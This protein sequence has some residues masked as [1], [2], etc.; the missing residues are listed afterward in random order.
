METIKEIKS[1]PVW[2]FALIVALVL[3]ITMFIFSIV[4]SILGSS[5]FSMM[6]FF[7]EMPMMNFNN[8]SVMGALYYIVMMPIMMFICSFLIAALAALIYNLL[9][10]RVGGIKLGL[11]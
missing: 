1:I 5:M 10:P 8:Y 11:E 2:S 7:N 3:A 9:A 4:M 6:P